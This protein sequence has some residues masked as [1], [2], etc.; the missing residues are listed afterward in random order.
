MG[1]I[2]PYGCFFMLSVYRKE[3]SLYVIKHIILAPDILDLENLDFVSV[4][5]LKNHT[6]NFNLAL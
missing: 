4:G 5:K 1:T 2:V 3:F 6:Q